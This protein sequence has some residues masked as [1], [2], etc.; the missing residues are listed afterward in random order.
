MGVL[1]AIVRSLRDEFFPAARR[2]RLVRRRLKPKS[3]PARVK[4]LLLLWCDWICRRA[5]IHC[6]H[7]PF[8]LD[9]PPVLSGVIEVQGWAV[10]VD[11]IDSVTASCNGSEFGRTYV[12]VRRPELTR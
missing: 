11:G 5:W 7:P 6:D 10:A 8:D 1:A 3:L 9:T 4:A 12:G 2:S